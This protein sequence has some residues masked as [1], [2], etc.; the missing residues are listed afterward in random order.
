[1]NKLYKIEYFPLESNDSV[2]V[3]VGAKDKK[4]AISAGHPS[5]IDVSVVECEYICVINEIITL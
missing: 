1:M 5:S 4:E 3:F 2:V